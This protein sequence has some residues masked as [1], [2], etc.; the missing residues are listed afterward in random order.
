VR[1]LVR[2]HKGITSADTLFTDDERQQLADA[3]SATVGTADLLGRSRIARKVQLHGEHGRRYHEADAFACFD[4]PTV[5]PLVPEEALRYFR[6]LV[7]TLTPPEGWAEE[8]RRRCFSLAVATETTLLERV[9]SLIAD[10]LETGKGISSAPHEIG[11]LLD[12]AG[13]TPRNSDY[14]SMVFRTNV[15]RAYMEGAQEQLNEVREHFGV[16]KYA[17]IRDGRQ[18]ADHEPHF[19][20]YYP[21]SARFEDVRGPR[22]FNCRCD[23]IPLSN[24]EWRELRAAGARVAEGYDDPVPTAG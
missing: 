1:R 6:A 18:G 4:E 24:D 23:F 9:Q 2:E 15:R 3:L 10:R 5:R 7:P 11:K 13:V 8:L 20:R 17:G 22:V 12:Q 21:T 16:W 19:D 14:A